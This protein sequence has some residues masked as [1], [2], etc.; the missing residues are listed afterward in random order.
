MSSAESGQYVSRAGDKLAGAGATLNIDFKNKVVLDVGSSTGGFT[1]YALSKG[2]AKVMAVEVGTNQLH[3]SL[4]LDPRIKLH[5][6]TD[7]RDFKTAE[8]PDIILIDVSFISLRQVLPVIAKLSSKDTQIVALLKP[9]FE[10]EAK[11]LNKGVIKNDS[12]RR[13]IIKEFEVW[14][15]KYFIIKAKTDSQVAG[16]K[17]NLERFYL[18][19]ILNSSGR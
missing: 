15:K 10:A 11:D 18:L 1:Q 4:R 17:G 16:T 13:Q 3:P 5:E 9:Q 14:A 8:K 12:M 7:I 2:A 6:K 19:K